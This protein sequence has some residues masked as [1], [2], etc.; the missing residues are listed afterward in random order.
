MR[1]QGRGRCNMV[2]RIV[3]S[4]PDRNATKFYPGFGA[5]VRLV[6]GSMVW[7]VFGPFCGRVLELFLWPDFFRCQ[8]L[9]K[10][11][12]QGDR[13]LINSV[14]KVLGILGVEIVGKWVRS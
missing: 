12:G 13:F 2:V 6:L 1:P 7:V 5:F 3:Y 4:H 10:L 14:I 9:E 8:A 11:S